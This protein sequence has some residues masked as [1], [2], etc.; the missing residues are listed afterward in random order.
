MGQLLDF[1]RIHDWMDAPSLGADCEDL[2]LSTRADYVSAPITPAPYSVPTEL[3]PCGMAHDHHRG[4]DGQWS[5]GTWLCL[6]SNLERQDRKTITTNLRHSRK[7]AALR[8]TGSLVSHPVW[9]PFLATDTDRGT[10]YRRIMNG[11]SFSAIAQELGV[12]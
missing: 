2:D 9:L 3:P 11:E 4:R 7:F 1:V 10:V 12:L 8:S 6:L 5:A